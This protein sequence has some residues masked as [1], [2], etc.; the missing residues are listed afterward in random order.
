[1]DPAVAAGIDPTVTESVIEEE[2]QADNSLTVGEE[3]ALSDDGTPA[4]PDDR[5]SQDKDQA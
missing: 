4:N 2:V 3:T 1:M 5:D